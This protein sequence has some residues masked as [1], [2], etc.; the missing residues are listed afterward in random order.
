MDDLVQ[1]KLRIGFNQIYKMTREYHLIVSNNERKKSKKYLKS[2]IS[3]MENIRFSKYEEVDA[4][5]QK[6][7]V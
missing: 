5:L 3:L 6:K 1:S 4:C 7:K 2:E